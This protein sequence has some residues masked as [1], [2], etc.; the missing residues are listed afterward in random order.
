MLRDSSIQIKFSEILQ[1]KFQKESLWLVI[2]RDST[3]Q[4]QKVCGKT[5]E[6][7]NKNRASNKEEGEEGIVE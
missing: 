2:Q 6:K 4:A 3:S 5:V 1:R 7:K